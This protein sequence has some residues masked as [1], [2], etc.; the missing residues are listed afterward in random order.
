MP[1]TNHDRL[2]SADIIEMNNSEETFGIFSE[3][4]RYIPEVRL[5]TASPIKKTQYKT[6]VQTGLP[7][8]GFRDS[9]V[10]I[11][12]GSP[13][14]E[15]RDVLLKFLDASWS[16]DQKVA[17]EAEWGER[18][19]VTLC[20]K[21]AMEA[22]LQK[23]AIQT[24]YGSQADAN[25]FTGLATLLPKSNSPMVFDAGGTAANTASS[26]FAIRTEL[27]GVQYAW[28]QDGTIDV[29]P[30]V[31][32]EQWDADMKKFWGYAQKVQAYIGLQVPSTQVIGRICNITAEEG[33]MASEGMI[34]KLLEQFPVGKEPN[35]IFMTKRSLEQIRSQRVATTTTGKEVPY[36]DKIFGIPIHVT[37]ALKNTEALLTAA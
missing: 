27:Q 32:A 18:A 7:T 29:G 8:V 9:N 35:L 6:L 33:H 14:I 10:G 15:A 21:A 16:L 31:D 30:I 4:S 34:A 12:Q 5:I 25:G 36:P 23:I 22:A 17:K 3:A 2:T 28:G 37:E 1:V 20:A 13:T 24:W 19:A 26:I 11:V